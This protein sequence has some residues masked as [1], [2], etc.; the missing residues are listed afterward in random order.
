[1]LVD[2]LA[3]LNL[4]VQIV[5]ELFDYESAYALLIEGIAGLAIESADFFGKFIGLILPPPFV[6][7]VVLGR[8]KN[9]G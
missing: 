3:Q 6:S 8:L 9:Y 4:S 1:M 5:L 7:V 2:L